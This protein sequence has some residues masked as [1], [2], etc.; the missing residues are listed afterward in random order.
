MDK[1]WRETQSGPV[2]EL[3]QGTDWLSVPSAVLVV[4]LAERRFP[5]MAA[6]ADILPSYEEMLLLRKTLGCPS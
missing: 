4:R 2:A 5:P 3:S 6:D 1:R